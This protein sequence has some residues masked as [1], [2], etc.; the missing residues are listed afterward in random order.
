[1][2]AATVALADEFTAGRC[3]TTASDKIFTCS[4]QILLSRVASL[5][6]RRYE[7]DVFYVN[8]H[9]HFKTFSCAR[10]IPE[11]SRNYM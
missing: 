6:W 11:T 8:R 1:M 10:Y 4:E 3:V 7:E 2:G 5:R 9:M